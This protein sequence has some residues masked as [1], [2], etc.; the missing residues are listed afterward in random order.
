MFSP[1]HNI[2][3]EEHYEKDLNSVTMENSDDS[4]YKHR[5]VIMQHY[6]GSTPFTVSKD[7]W[8]TKEDTLSPH[9]NHTLY[10]P[11]Y[12]KKAHVALK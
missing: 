7:K 8:Y 1:L 12:A 5:K 4:H 9:V 3:N 11:R 6:C 2:T 10:V